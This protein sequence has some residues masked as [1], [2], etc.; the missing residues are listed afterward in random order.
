MFDAISF[1]FLYGE[2]GGNYVSEL[3]DQWIKQKTL[4]IS[5]KYFLRIICSK[6]RRCQRNINVFFRKKQFR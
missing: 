2:M 4:H 3:R 1:S 6:V 5:K